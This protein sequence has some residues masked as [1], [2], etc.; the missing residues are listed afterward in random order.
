MHDVGQSYIERVLSP[1]RILE[2]L[3]GSLGLGSVALAVDEPRASFVMQ[4]WALPLIFVSALALGPY[5]ARILS[6]AWSGYRPIRGVRMAQAGVLGL[7][8]SVG[9][10]VVL[11]KPFPV[12]AATGLVVLSLVMLAIDLRRSRDI[13]E[14]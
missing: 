3:A 6:Q 7:T 4:L 2:T 13:R 14:R 9:I 8:A 1:L 12:P 11:V 10:A 5:L